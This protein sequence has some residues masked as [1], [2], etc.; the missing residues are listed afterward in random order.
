VERHGA[1]DGGAGAQRQQQ[2]AADAPHRAE[3]E[4]RRA[5]P[6]A[7]PELDDGCISGAM[8]MAP[9]TTAV[10]PWA[11]PTVAISTAIESWSQ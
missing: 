5:Q 6:E 7:D 4:Q 3:G 2:A 8:S 11:R 1:R 10:L 9:I